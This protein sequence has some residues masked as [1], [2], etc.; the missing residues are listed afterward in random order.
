VSREFDAI[1]LAGGRGSRMG[2]VR[3]PDLTVGGRRL[4]DIALAAVR[5]ARRV[6]VVGDVEVPSGVLCTR[7]D[8]PFGG[9]VAGVEAGFAALEGHCEW[10]LLLASD[11][12]DAEAAVAALRSADPGPQWDGACLLDED[13]RLQWLL[14]QYRSDAL[15][16][17]LAERGD[18]PL[19]AMH[20][21]LRPLSLLG[22]DPGPASVADLDTIED[23]AAWSTARGGAR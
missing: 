19:T 7:E 13:G 4:L 9:P 12:P 20:R 8:P 21:L 5:G 23:L 11:L 14:G 3:K 10:T 2:G 18:P 16:R 15:A 1:V 6:V 17:R 22:V